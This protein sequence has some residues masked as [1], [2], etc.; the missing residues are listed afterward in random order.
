[1]PTENTRCLYCYEPLSA[2]EV[3]YH[4]RCSRQFFGTEEPPDL[5][6][7]LN[8]MY[9]LANQI[10]R[11]SVSV[12]GVQ[13]KLSMD[14]ESFTQARKRKRFTIV[15]MWGKYVLKPPTEQYESLPENEDLTMHLADLYKLRTVPHSLVRLKSGELAYI[16]K[17]IDRVDARKLSMEDMCQLTERLTEDKYKGSMEQVGKIIRKFSENPGF[18]LV[19][20]FELTLFCFL[21]GNADM[22]LKNFSLIRSVEGLVT[23]APAY[24]LIA[25]KLAM[26]ADPEEVALTINGKKRNLR[27][28]DFEAFADT[29]GINDKVRRSSFEKFAEGYE[30]ARALVGKSFLS[31]SLREA[32]LS[33]LAARSRQLGITES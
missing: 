21:T 16:T 2:G 29:L 12:T 26:P 8:Q 24:D 1:V 22:H 18:D 31:K 30:S 25:T 17:R 9:E 11:S 13:A 27:R 14:V 28:S 32:Y 4:S 20:F 19:E 3:D 5:P 33:L 6:F 10:I 15:G 7:E 23:L